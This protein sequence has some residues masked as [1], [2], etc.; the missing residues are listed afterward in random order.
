MDEDGS[1]TI[2]DPQVPDYVQACSPEGSTGA[3]PSSL[4]LP[5]ANDQCNGGMVD[6][7]NMGPSCSSSH[8][9]DAGYESASSP[10]NGSYFSPQ[11][12]SPV[13][14]YDNGN[15]RGYAPDLNNPRSLI[16]GQN[17]SLGV[18][19]SPAATMTQNNCDY[20]QGEHPMDVL[21]DTSTEFS[22]PALDEILRSLINQPTSDNL[23]VNMALVYSSIESL[24]SKSPPTVSTS[25]KNPA[26]NSYEYLKPETKAT[27]N[28]LPFP[29]RKLSEKRTDKPLLRS[30][31]TMPKEAIPSQPPGGFIQ[32]CNK[33]DEKASAFAKGVNNPVAKQVNKS[34]Q[35]QNQTC[36]NNNNYRASVSGSFSEC[37]NGPVDNMDNSEALDFDEIPEYALQYLVNDFTDAQAQALIAD[38][39]GEGGLQ[40]DSFMDTS[41][42]DFTK[43]FVSSLESQSAN[44][45][46]GSESVGFSS[47]A[48]S[49][50]GSNI[51]FSQCKTACYSLGTSTKCNSNP[52][53]NLNSGLNGSSMSLGNYRSGNSGHDHVYHQSVNRLN[54][55]NRPRFHK[56]PENRGMCDRINGGQNTCHSQTQTSEH[57]MSELERHLRNKLTSRAM[58]CSGGQSRC[59][60]NSDKP[61]LQQLLT[62]EL[63][64]DMY[65]KMEK[66]R[67]E[68]KSS[69]QK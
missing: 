13:C 33:K 6:P 67:F 44:V 63:T 8:S 17:C 55:Q 36:R 43:D 29:Q 26:A 21:A 34:A 47:L 11:M 14:S 27:N 39:Q 41:E 48:G 19:Y 68:G 5:H 53:Q 38:L 22:N 49:Q 28:T 24:T 51:P 50:T 40:N 65:M 59:I 16:Q 4:C 52:Q 23:D 58:G 56:T 57:C 20:I 46:T 1:N 30:F 9:E 18:G 42:S 61:F 54:G 69:V 25:V 64:N 45:S 32:M 60:M 10:Y 7:Q 3:Y 35:I 62:G 2:I 15:D 66:K 12:V 31:L 37:E